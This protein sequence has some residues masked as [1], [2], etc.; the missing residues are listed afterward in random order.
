[1]YKGG[2]RKVILVQFDSTALIPYL[3]G[4]HRPPP[5][6]PPGKGIFDHATLKNYFS[7]VIY[8]SQ[9]SFSLAVPYKA[10]PHW[11]GQKLNFE[12]KNIS[13]SGNP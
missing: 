4:P 12:K 5:P 7:V 9:G 8:I 6:P 1:M 11:K 13:V 2:R 10:I 3:I